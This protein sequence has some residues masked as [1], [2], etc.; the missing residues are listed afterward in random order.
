[1]KK[2]IVLFTLLVM[3][4]PAFALTYYLKSQR[5]VNGVTY[6]YYNGGHVLTVG[7][8][9]RCPRTIQRGL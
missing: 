9:G 7:G 8:L 6:C 1:M 2:L 3:S 4:S 5:T